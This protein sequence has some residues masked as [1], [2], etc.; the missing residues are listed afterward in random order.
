MAEQKY[1]LATIGTPGKGGW[2]QFDWDKDLQSVRP[3]YE[4]TIVILRNGRS[5]LLAG[6]R[7][8]V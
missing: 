3:H 2:V 8:G 5:Y 7:Y 4:D 6:R 1:D